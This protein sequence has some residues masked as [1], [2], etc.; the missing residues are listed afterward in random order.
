MGLSQPGPDPHVALGR[1]LVA[2][3]P[4]DLHEDE[5]HVAAGRGVAVDLGQQLMA[6]VVVNRLVVVLALGAQ[7]E[8][9]ATDVARGGVGVCL[10]YTSDAADE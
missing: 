1:I 10:L 6:G 7:F 5:E 2:F 4:V 8:Q 3:E 9:A